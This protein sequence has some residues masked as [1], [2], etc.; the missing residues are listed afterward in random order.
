LD[1]CAPCSGNVCLWPGRVGAL[2]L[3]RGPGYAVLS[4]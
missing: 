1:G 3:E 4:A 2:V